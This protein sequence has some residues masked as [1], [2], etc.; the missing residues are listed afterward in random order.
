MD[1]IVRDYYASVVGEASVRFTTAMYDGTNDVQ[2]RV[3]PIDGGYAIVAKG[4]VVCFIE[5]GTGR[6]P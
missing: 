4:E 2:V 3:D 1:R 5:F 6:L